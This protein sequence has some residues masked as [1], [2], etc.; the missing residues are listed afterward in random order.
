MANAD[1]ISKAD[2]DFVTDAAAAL[3]A[4]HREDAD[5]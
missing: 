2:R 3:R 1:E 4:L 5:R